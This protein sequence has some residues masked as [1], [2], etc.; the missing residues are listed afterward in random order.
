MAPHAY[1]MFHFT[2]P[3]EG[4]YQKCWLKW[5]WCHTKPKYFSNLVDSVIIMRK[6]SFKDIIIREINED[7]T[8]VFFFYYFLFF[9]NAASP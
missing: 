2:A 4:L 5:I 8:N 6:D 9:I 3:G 7:R 1:F